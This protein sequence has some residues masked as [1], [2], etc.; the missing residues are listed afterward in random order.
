VDKNQGAMI[1]LLLQRLLAAAGRFAAAALGLLVLIELAYGVLGASRV[2]L[3]SPG[4]FGEV[5][6]GIAPRRP[7]WETLLLERGL[8]TGRILLLALP[9]TLLVG[10]AWGILGARLRRLRVPRLL[11]APFAA[12]ACAPGFWLVGLVAVHS[13]HHWQRPGF[14]GD[15]VVES[16]PDLLAWWHAAVL[17]LPLAAAA[18]AWQILAVARTIEAEAARP[19]ARALFVEGV[20]DEAIFYR[21]VLRRAVP[22]LLARLDGTLPALLGGLVVLEPAFR[23][24]GIGALLVDSVRLGSYSG[25]LLAS[26]SLVAL[27]LFATLLRELVSAAAS[28]S[29][30]LP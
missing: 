23:Y 28:P 10:Y 13:Y 25:I 4:A 18:V 27:S 19:W 15:L 16:G 29:P 22:A 7:G 3:W 21:H 6:G 14:A 20:E 11:A 9:A 2:H 24:P 30:A 12:L 5:P 17:A 8:A 1:H 26:L